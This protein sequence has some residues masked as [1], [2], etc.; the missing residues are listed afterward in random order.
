MKRVVNK[1]IRSAKKRS[2]MSAPT[3][4]PDAARRTFVK[5]AL[6]V[7]PTILTLSAA[8][9]FAKAGS[10]KPKPRRNLHPAHPTHPGKG[11]GHEKRFM[12]SKRP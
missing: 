1:G 10:E 3:E 11:K 6:Y 5:R 12:H 2:E 8:P 4:L 7:P 9:A